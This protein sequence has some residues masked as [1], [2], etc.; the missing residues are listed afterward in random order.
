MFVV[1]VEFVIEEEHV[2]DFRQ[3]ALL[4]SQ[5]SLKHEEACRVFDVCSDPECPTDWFFYE[6]YD[7]RAAFDR[8]RETKH[9]A[10]Y[11]AAVTPWIVSKD[12]RFLERVS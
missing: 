11:T 8:H 9:F 3:Q 6:V 4:Q 12:I 1:A 7:D 10:N 5:N 2:E